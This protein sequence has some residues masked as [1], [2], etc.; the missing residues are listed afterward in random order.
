MPEELKTS[1]VITL[2][3]FFPLISLMGPDNCSWL[4][5]Q[6][7]L[8]VSC[9]VYLVIELPDATSIVVLATYVNQL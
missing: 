8:C 3:V 4:I 2:L 6:I 7:A 1:Q 5:L 9:V